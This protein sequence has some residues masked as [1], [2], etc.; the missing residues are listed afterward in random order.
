M[1][2]IYEL[3]LLSILLEIGHHRLIKHAAADRNLLIAILLLLLLLVNWLS[4]NTRGHS[5]HT[6]HG[7]GVVLLKTLGLGAGWAERLGLPVV[8][9]A[10]HSSGI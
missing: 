9:A 4:P 6:V 1:T 10:S 7:H 3:R 8:T 5:T 2:I